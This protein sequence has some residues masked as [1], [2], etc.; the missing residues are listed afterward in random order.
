VKL[1]PWARNLHVA[2][3]L[4]DWLMDSKYGPCNSD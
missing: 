3:A 2:Q 4:A 1:L